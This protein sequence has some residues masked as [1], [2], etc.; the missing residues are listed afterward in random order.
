MSLGVDNAVVIID[1]A[2]N[3]EGVCRDAGSME[4]DLLDMV[5]MASDLCDLSQVTACRCGEGMCSRSCSCSFSLSLSLSRDCG[6][7]CLSVL[8][9][10]LGCLQYSVCD[11]K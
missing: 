9:A 2:H 6:C 8:V 5:A 7:V 1:E 11:T 4:L 3:V 10:F